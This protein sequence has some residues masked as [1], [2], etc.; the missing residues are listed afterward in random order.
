MISVL[1][2]GMLDGNQLSLKQ[3]Y[4][5]Q[6]RLSSAEAKYITFSLRTSGIWSTGD[7]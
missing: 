7:R 1:C 6:I 5:R 2:F 4:G 3:N